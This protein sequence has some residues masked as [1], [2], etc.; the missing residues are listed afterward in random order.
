MRY[1]RQ[2]TLIGPEAQQRL[3]GAHV[4]VI[5]A[6]GLGSPVLLYLAGAGIGRITVIDADVVEQSNLHRQVIHQDQNVG[7][8]KAQSARDAMLALNPTVAVDVVND[9]LTWDNAM[10]LLAGADIIVDGTDNFDTRHI[11]SHA[12]ARLGVPHVWGSILGH[13]AQVSVFWAGHGPVYE[14]VFATP[15]PVGAVPSCA[16]SGVLGPVV[17]IAGTTMAMEVLKIVTGLGTTLLGT[18]G[19][20]D[21]LAGTWEYIPLVADPSVTERVRAGE[22][23]RQHNVEQVDTIPDGATLID[24]REPEELRA[25]IDG[26]ISL[27]L[28]QI[29]SGAVPPSLPEGRPVVVYC[30]TGVRSIEAVELLRER[31]LSQLTS[32]RG[33]FEK[34]LEV[35]GSR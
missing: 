33:G 24:V 17:G 1:L 9:R 11:A 13:E 35:H 16:Q 34:W 6:G 10:S 8:A 5:G 22:P 25:T 32:L 21:G 2:E 3:R 23:P 18:I 31:G 28:S 29:R 26:A 14:D 19:Y 4:A 20:Y 30:A 7:Q 12:A 27:P 15:P